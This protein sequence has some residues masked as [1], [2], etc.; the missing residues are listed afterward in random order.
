MERERDLF[1]LMARRWQG[2]MHALME[3]RRREGASEA[4]RRIEDDILLGGR[5]ET[6]IFGLG[7]MLGGFH[8]DSDDDDD[9]HHNDQDEDDDISD[10]DAGEEADEGDEDEEEVDDDEDE[11]EEEETG[12]DAD[13]DHNIRDELDES[14]GEMDAED[15]MSQQDIGEQ[16]IEVSMASDDNGVA[17]RVPFDTE[18][19]D[20]NDEIDSDNS[21]GSESS[22]GVILSATGA[23][24]QS[25]GKQIMVR[26][27]I[28]TVSMSSDEL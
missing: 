19:V 8:T 20:D 17:D 24:I 10:H 11:D 13:G 12:I 9:D 23:G 6:L 15:T 1:R 25:S 16:P 14:D 18:S 5:E 7:T 4:V 28:R 27:Q 26:P 2:R 3:E 21:S 22:G